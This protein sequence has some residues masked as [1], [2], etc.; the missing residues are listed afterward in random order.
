[1]ESSSPSRTAQR[2]R[3]VSNEVPTN[4]SNQ[5]ENSSSAT[6]P[7]T[8]P[9][10]SPRPTRVLHSGK[11][12]SASAQR[13]APAS[14]PKSPVQWLDQNT[15]N[16][17]GDPA[18][19]Q[20][21]PKPSRTRR[22]LNAV[23]SVF[24]RTKKEAASKPAA[25]ADAPA[26][27]VVSPS[28]TRSYV[29]V[30]HHPSTSPRSPL[31]T[32]KSDD[33]VPEL[34]T[35][36]EG[37]G[38]SD[39]GENQVSNQ[40]E[41][42]TPFM[43]LPNSVRKTFGCVRKT[44]NDKTPGH[45]WTL[46]A[47]RG[48]GHKYGVRDNDLKPFKGAV[49]LHEYACESRYSI[50]RDFRDIHPEDAQGVKKVALYL[51]RAFAFGANF[52]DWLGQ[53][54][55]GHGASGGL[56]LA[57]T[58]L[59]NCAPGSVEVVD[60]TSL[61]RKGAG[62]LGLGLGQLSA[63]ANMAVSLFAIGG[64][65]VVG[66]VAGITALVTYMIAYTLLAIG[67]TVLTGIVGGAILVS[68]LVVRAIK[69]ALRLA[70]TAPATIFNWGGPV[71]GYNLFYNCDRGADK[72][73]IALALA[74]A[75]ASEAR[76]QV[77]D[78]R[79]ANLEAQIAGERLAHGPEQLAHLKRAAED[80]NQA[81]AILKL[82]EVED[83]LN[84]HNRAALGYSK[85]Y[86]IGNMLKVEF[87]DNSLLYFKYGKGINKA[88]L[89]QYQRELLNMHHPKN[90]IDA[91]V[92]RYTPDVAPEHVEA[93]RELIKERLVLTLLYLQ[94]N[95]PAK[96]IERLALLSR[97]DSSLVRLV[98][99]NPP[100]GKKGGSPKALSPDSSQGRKTRGQ[101]FAREQ[102]QADA[103]LNMSGSREEEWTEVK[104]R[105]KLHRRGEK[106]TGTFDTLA[107]FSD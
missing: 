81:L 54:V 107:D 103:N 82:Q 19:S 1:M 61:L 32:T 49:K 55:L 106:R 69:L 47:E 88:R 68:Y 70:L 71:A 44:I 13:M 3:S 99:S 58:F 30:A 94:G 8:P 67:A 64:R 33:E 101:E 28:K 89:P 72:K 90:E 11:Q 9:A 14:S 45:S 62:V 38:S 83:T 98:R 95:L 60:G 77:S 18:V 86:A 100:Q 21:P 51:G 22:A 91:R 6:P 93:V 87:V 48:T 29:D 50:F 75:A 85:F 65:V 24:T 92:A 73:R 4:Q 2:Q 97:D 36:K 96:G 63:I 27:P 105:R 7:A 25:V 76:S 46:A 84:E 41:A 53:V 56:G 102:A 17:F 52:G 37:D 43:C 20:E 31:V 57:T 12:D 39:E 79:S 42:Y 74:A 80:A 26:S 35:D 23:S 34:E 40:R 5:S 66:V 15:E 10:T 59:N 16:P 104:G 78:A